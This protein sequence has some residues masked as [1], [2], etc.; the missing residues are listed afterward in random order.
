MK[1][2][3][4]PPEDGASSF[5]QEPATS[6][7]DAPAAAAGIAAVEAHAT[8]RHD[9]H[10]FRTRSSMP[11]HRVLTHEGLR[12]F[13]PIAAVYAALWPLAWVLLWSFRLPFSELPAGLWHA[14]EMI[15]GAWGAAL[16]GFLTTAPA[17]WTDTPRPRGEA[18]WALAALWA[19]GRLAG[20]L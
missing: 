16:L 12:L 11:L 13:F 3:V 15:L 2:P 9:A 6:P 8:R 14:Q 5:P 20:L 4:P 18:V 19:V 1:V 7:H 10:S 17:E